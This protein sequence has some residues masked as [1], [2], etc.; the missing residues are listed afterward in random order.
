VKLTLTP[1]P[2]FVAAAAFTLLTAVAPA[3]VVTIPSVLGSSTPFSGSFVPANLFDGLPNEFASQGTGAGTFV[4]M[5]FGAPVAMD[6]MVFMTRGNTVD[7]VGTTRL[8]LSNDP[9]F[10]TGN[11]VFNF[12]P[13][14][15]NAQA[16]ILSFASTTA[17]YA[18]WEAFT[19]TGTSPN[20][21]GRELRFLN[22]PGGSVIRPS[23]AYN[24]APQFSAQYATANAANGDAGQ[25]AGPGV[26]YA[27]QGQGVNTFVDFDLG[28]I[29]G[30]SGFDFFDRLAA[31]DRTTAFNLIF[32]DDSS[33]FSSP[34]AT[35]SFTPGATGW[36]YSQNFA[37]VNARYVRIDATAVASVNNNAGVQEMVFYA[38]PEPSTLLLAGLA[39]ALTLTRRRR[40]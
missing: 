24:S 6:R 28:G 31:V 9:T 15:N 29:V 11:T 22:T 23:T 27:S 18:R 32:D 14:G 30:V 3:T 16:P 19:S 10:T 2:G 40:Q 20:L 21:G 26:E 4:S 39:G 5:D 25:G 7:V 17:R 1:S 33:T 13:S 35:L 37:A 12:T 36:G 38:V 34:V 8:T